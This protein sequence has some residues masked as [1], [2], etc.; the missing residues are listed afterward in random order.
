MHWFS[1]VVAGTC[2]GFA[3]GSSVGR[4]S[5]RTVDRTS[6]VRLLPMSSHGGIGLTVSGTL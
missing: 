2:L 3:L 6:S 4:G 5:R 1:D